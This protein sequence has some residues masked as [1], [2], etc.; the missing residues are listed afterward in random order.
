MSGAPP[1]PGLGD[2]GF[3]AKPQEQDGDQGR[4]R[5]NRRQ[6]CHCDA[7]AE[8]SE[9]RR[10]DPSERQATRVS[11][12]GD[13]RFARL[14]QALGREDV[15]EFVR[16]AGPGEIDEIEENGG[17]EQ[18]RCGPAVAEDAPTGE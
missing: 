5:Q 10:H 6:P 14:Q 18:S 17:E 3:A 12:L 9:E 11:S 1:S 16:M 2:P 13:A 8:Q 15:V 4:R 7:V